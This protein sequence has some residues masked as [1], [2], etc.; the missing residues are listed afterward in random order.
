MKHLL[1]FSASLF[2]VVCLITFAFVGCASTKPT[3]FSNVNPSGPTAFEQRLFN[4]ETN[5]R[6]QIVTVTNTVTLTQT[7]IAVVTVT[8]AVGVPVSQTNYSTVI[9]F[10]TNTVSVTNEVPTYTLTPGTGAAAIQATGSGIAGIFGYGGLTSAAIAGLFA[11]YLGFRNRALK[12]DATTASQVSGVLAQN[13]E[14]LQTVLATT[15]QGQQLAPLI[16][17]YLVQHQSEAG[18]VTQVAE[19]V[20]NVSSPDAT[21]SAAAILNLLKQLQ[22]QAPA[23]VVKV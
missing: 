5:S 6:P 1:K 3:L 23:P 15:P 22:L 17:N 21:A 16:T 14:T 18:V 2:T 12:G 9:S 4:I 11:A 20:K 8:N 10:A 7:N 13:I 19:L